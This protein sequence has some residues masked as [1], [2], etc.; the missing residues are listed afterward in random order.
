MEWLNELFGDFDAEA[1]AKNLIAEQEAEAARIADLKA[2]MAAA[3]AAEIAN[4][5]PR[6]MGSG[7]LPQFVHRA[8]GVCFKCGG[9]GTV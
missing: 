2:R 3:E 8:G 5:C 7:K 4:R 6:C 1:S 9:T